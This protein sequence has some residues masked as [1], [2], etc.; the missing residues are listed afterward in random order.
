MT[1]HPFRLHHQGA[2]RQSR[3]RKIVHQ[4]VSSNRF[5]IAGVLLLGVVIPE[6]LHPLFAS[7]QAWARPIAPLDPML[8]ATAAALLLAHLMLRRTSPLPFVDAKIIILPVFTVAFAT[9]MF[10]MSLMFRKLGFYHLATGFMA[11]IIWNTGLTVLRSRLGCPV[12]ALVGIPEVTAEMQAAR[13]IWLP[14]NQTRMP[15]GVHAI[16]YDS[17]RDYP[18]AWERFF[19]RAVLRNIPV[20][21]LDHVSEMMTGRVRLRSKP[22]LVF[23]QLLP[24]LPYLRLKRILD[25]SLALFLLPLVLVI[26]ACCCLLIRFESRG[27]PIFRQT[28]VGYQGRLFTCYKL[29]TMRN[30]VAGPLYTQERDPR[31]TRLGHLLRMSRLDELPQIFNVLFGDMSW[32]GPRPE[33]LRLSRDYDRSIPFYCYRHSVRPGISGWAAVHQGNVALAD[34]VTV[35]LEYDFYYIK[36]FSIWLDFAIILMTIRTMVTGFGSR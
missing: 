18:P 28:R 25:F 24:S 31:I 27:S 21:D 29:R 12:L 32:I 1:V 33:A 7:E 34:A 22:E 17:S 19:A 3:L 20:Y 10:L 36:Y 35:K 4:L 6:L 9:V 30:D 11:G 15:S 26:L 2:Y 14:W 13:V 16:V 23:G 8:Y 5:A